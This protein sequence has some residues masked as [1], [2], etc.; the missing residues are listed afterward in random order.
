MLLPSTFIEMK[1]W[2]PTNECNEYLEWNEF[3]AAIPEFQQRAAAAFIFNFNLKLKRKAAAGKQE[4][5]ERADGEW[6]GVKFNLGYMVA[7]IHS[8]NPLAWN[9]FC[10]LALKWKVKWNENECRHS[11]INPL[12]SFVHFIPFHFTQCLLPACWPAFISN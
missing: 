10:L 12:R 2:K 9:Y 11:I 7:P 6:N 5:M 1:E 8:A 3:V 4:R